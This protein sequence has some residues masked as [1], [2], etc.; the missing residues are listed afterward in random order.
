MNF[1]NLSDE[2]KLFIATV[3]GEAGGSSEATQRAVAHVIMNRVGYKDWSNRD[4]VAKNLT[5]DQFSSID[6]PNNQPFQE[7]QKYL[8]NRDGSNP[9]LEKMVNTAMNVY[10]KKDPDFTG[11][12]VMFYSPKAQAQLHKADPANYPKPHPVDWN[13]DELLHLAVPGA[14]ED[15][16]Q[17]YKYK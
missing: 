5:S 14:E 3:A 11:G 2:Q 8:K 10:H 7:M 17:F 13:F 6:D 15:D 16:F 4:T 9:R 12:A 1:P